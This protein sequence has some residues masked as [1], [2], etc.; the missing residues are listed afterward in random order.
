MPTTKDYLQMRKNRMTYSTFFDYFV[1]TVVS[2]H[3]YDLMARSQ[4]LSNF[5]TVTDEAFALLLH[6]NQEGRWNE[7]ATLNVTKSTILGAYTDG[8][9][10]QKE[11]GS[12]RKN[13]GWTN[14][15]MARFNELCLMVMIDR[16]EPH[17]KDF[18]EMYL[19]HRIHLHDQK[20]L[21]RKK[22][23]SAEYE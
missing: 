2:C 23:R 8:G 9:R 15:G 3:T 21:N 14:E 19:K 17:A 7:M 18:E 6:E 12:S 4:T 16:Q 10:P 5:V 13:R 11:T 1:R 22:R 20:N